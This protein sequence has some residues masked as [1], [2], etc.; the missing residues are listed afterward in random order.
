MAGRAQPST[1]R[2]ALGL[3]HQAACKAA[4][5][6]A[7][8]TA[9]AAPRAHHHFAAVQRLENM[10]RGAPPNL[11]GLAVGVTQVL[12]PLCIDRPLPQRIW[13]GVCPH[14]RGSRGVCTAQ[15]CSNK[16]ILRRHMLQ[17]GCR[18]MTMG[19]CPFFRALARCQMACR[20]MMQAAI[21]SPA[22]PTG[23][24]SPLVTPSSPAPAQA[25]GA[26]HTQPS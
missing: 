17:A 14:K 12:N 6:C 7:V 5:C 16:R 3:A 25:T 9:F 10:G 11:N 19:E 13:Q 24:P 23:T 22:A 4:P 15:L 21:A 8:C 20:L 1:A 2:Q 18:R 26:G